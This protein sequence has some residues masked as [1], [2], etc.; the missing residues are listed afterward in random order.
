MRRQ[1]RSRRP[2]VLAG[3][4]KK[5]GAAAYRWG[6]GGGAARMVAREPWAVLGEGD[7]AG[8]RASCGLQELR[9]CAAVGRSGRT[10][11][12]VSDGDG[13]CNCNLVQSGAHALITTTAVILARHQIMR[14]AACM[15][16]RGFVRAWLLPCY[17]GSERLPGATLGV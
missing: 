9:A 2:T 3:G 12:C 11:V 17:V 15:G 14:P 7:H 5:A 8:C 16:V 4:E 6:G 13:G 10:L 1:Q